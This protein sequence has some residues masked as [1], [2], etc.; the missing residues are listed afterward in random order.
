MVKVK[1]E[2]ARK[3]LR[4]RF[5]KVAKIRIVAHTGDVL[6]FV[7]LFNPATGADDMMLF[8]PTDLDKRRNVPFVSARPI[9]S[10]RASDEYHALRFDE[11]TA[12]V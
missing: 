10:S 3:D 5:G 2:Y 6:V 7:N 11:L 1:D 4:G 12:N 9:Q 8:D